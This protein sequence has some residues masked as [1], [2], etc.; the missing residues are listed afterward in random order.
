LV[1]AHRRHRLADTGYSLPINNV[2][3]SPARAQESSVGKGTKLKICLPKGELL[4][5]L[6]RV[7]SVFRRRNPMGLLA[8][9]NG[10]RRQNKKGLP[11][12][13]TLLFQYI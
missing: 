3:E 10:R 1:N 4:E 12:L 8:V 2:G 7:L 5:H 11:A 13:E 9:G 6:A